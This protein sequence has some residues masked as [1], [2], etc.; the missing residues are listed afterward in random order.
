LVGGL[1]V[2]AIVAAAVVVLWPSL[3]ARIVPPQKSYDADVGEMSRRLG[4]LEGAA[5]GAV[6]DRA[7][8]ADV[9]KRLAALEQA[10]Q[11]PPPED[12]RVAALADKVD[13]LAGQ[14]ATLH[15]PAEAEAD[16]RQL[17]TKAEAAAQDARSAAGQRQSAEAL[18]V[19]VGQLRDV[20]ERGGSYAAELAAARKVAPEDAAAALDTLAA[21]ADTGVTPRVELSSSFPAVAAAIARAGLFG[22]AAEGFWGH[23]EQEAA[24]L[25]TVRRVDGQGK[26]PASVAARAEKDLS[27]GDLEG[28]LKEMAT[29]E[30][31]PA[32]EAR[33]WMT[34][35]E[36]R[37]KAE[38][39]LSELTAK[40]GTAVKPAA[41]D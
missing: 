27:Q 19:V 34:A 32:T 10:V 11:A 20:V 35:A 1:V 41:A 36:A 9:G 15:A 31:A 17:V 33:A 18:L 6:S 2:A 25:V 16:M 22:T 7:T 13:Q 4:A 40:A 5:G 26:D 28:A 29:L 23:L 14:V 30:G 24:T 21:T 3:R 38:G 39:A 12:P 37:L 8:L